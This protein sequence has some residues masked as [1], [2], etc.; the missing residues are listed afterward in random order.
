MQKGLAVHLL[1][2][3]RSVPEAVASAR[4]ERAE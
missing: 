4:V 3:G 1:H 2:I